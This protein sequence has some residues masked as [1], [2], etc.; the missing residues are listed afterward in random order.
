MRGS[1]QLISTPSTISQPPQPFL[2]PLNLFKPAGVKNVVV[3]NALNLP[4]EQNDRL[5]ELV[6]AQMRAIQT[7]AFSE[8]F[9]LGC[10]HA[11]WEARERED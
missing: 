9:K 6:L 1:P 4:L 10:E 8:G 5:V 3:G 2:N 7:E 11:E